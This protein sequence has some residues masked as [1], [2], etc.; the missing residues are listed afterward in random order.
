M[1]EGMQECVRRGLTT[2]HLGRTDRH[3]DGLRRF[4]LSLGAEE[5]DLHY[6]RFHPEEGRWTPVLPANPAFLPG[7]VFRSLPL[8]VNQLAGTMLYRHLH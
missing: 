6:S 1:W 3:H 5:K 4:K 7:A 8:T 2:L